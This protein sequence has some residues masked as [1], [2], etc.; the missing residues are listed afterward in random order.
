MKSNV[1]PHHNFDAA[2]DQEIHRGRYGKKR[3]S[4]MSMILSLLSLILMVVAGFSMFKDHL[5]KLNVLG[6]KINLE[7]LQSLANNV[8]QQLNIDINH[9]EQYVQFLV[10]GIYAF[11]IAC[12][13]SII[14][15]IITLI[16]NRTAIKIIN[17]FL[18]LITV[19][20][21]VALIFIS[22]EA[23]KRISDGISQFYITVKP[24]EVIVPDDAIFNAIILT[25]SSLILLLVNLFFRNK[26]PIY[27]RK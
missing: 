16:F 8:H 22:K 9:A 11:L 3:R 10:Y 4:W 25:G 13:L 27:K 1:Q 18:T 15:H 2:F 14:L 12:L 5:F 7:S 24:E 17:L 6:K 23:A 26:P 21:P 20:I 19:I